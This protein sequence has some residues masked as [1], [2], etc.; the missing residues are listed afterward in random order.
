MLNNAQKVALAQ[1]VGGVRQYNNLISLMDN[2]TQF[3]ELVAGASSSTGYL[4]MQAEEYAESWEAAKNRLTA[5]WQGI[6]DQLIDDKFFIKV[7][8]FFA[9]L[10]RF[11]GQIIE[12]A[13]GLRGVISLLVM[14][15]SSLD[16]DKFANNLRQIKDTL[17][18]I[19]DALTGVQESANIDLKGNFLDIVFTQNAVTDNTQIMRLLDDEVAMLEKINILEA[20]N[21]TEEAAVLRAKLDRHAEELKA[22]IK[23]EQEL[24]N[25]KNLLQ[26]ITAVAN[27]ADS[28]LN[29]L[30]KLSITSANWSS[31]ARDLGQLRGKSDNE[32]LDIAAELNKRYR[33]QATSNI[34]EA[35]IFGGLSVDDAVAQ[36]E[37]KAQTGI[38][39]IIQKVQSYT[40]TF[41]AN[42][43]NKA[44]LQELLG[45]D[46]DNLQLTD[47]KFA[48]LK[49]K[50][51]G[52]QQ[53]KELASQKG[54]AA[55]QEEI[56]DLNEQ[57]VIV[58]RVIDTLLKYGQLTVQ[59][60]QELERMRGAANED[61]ANWSNMAVSAIRAAA[62]VS[63]LSNAMNGAV[64]AIKEFQGGSIDLGQLLS[65]LTGSAMSAV[66]AISTLS[67]VLQKMNIATATTFG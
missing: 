27:L 29:G 30:Q 39:Q 49:D 8:D 24:E 59:Q 3:Q 4:G 1:T 36:A 40:K 50:F 53:A 23:N 45:L 58:N 55:S 52:L 42:G 12:G 46:E 2:Y 43:G 11:I 41:T 66:M 38:K 33:G 28:D 9:G 37:E 64:T 14:G 57:E 62:A 61:N 60:R 48:E 35:V 22:L 31:F 56:D 6:Y 17:L 5:A 51:T 21:N 54:R 18:L 26:E 16:P 20:D 65:R 44:G 10:V 25:T 63:S 15:L 67:S 47:E 34:L 7:T 32:Q 19:K 13:G